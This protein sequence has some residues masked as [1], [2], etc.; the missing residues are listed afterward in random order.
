MITLGENL[1]VLADSQMTGT[2]V[3]AGSIIAL[4]ILAV[5][6]LSMRKSV[7]DAPELP[8]A[9]HPEAEPPAVEDEPVKP[10]EK[11]AAGTPGFVLPLPTEAPPTP[12]SPVKAVQAAP[13]EPAPVRPDPRPPDPVL[14]SEETFDLGRRGFSLPMT[15]ES[16]TQPAST[17][18]AQQHLLVF[19]SGARLGESIRLDDFPNGQCAIGRSEVP[20]NQVV[21]RDDLK[22]SRVQ[23][24]ILERDDLGQY[25]IRDN[26][27]ANKVFV[28]EQCLDSAPVPL[29]SGDKIRLGLTEF[30][31]VT[32]PVS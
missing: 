8:E 20:E 10:V 24:A 25:T 28:N 2:I 19:S 1:F 15:P 5:I 11:R 32:K 7:A 18:R 30:E 9:R 12:A 14:P 17:A 13:P 22:V 27:S 29:S 21:V 3:I 16:T 23:H 4:I 31:F 26:N 6:F